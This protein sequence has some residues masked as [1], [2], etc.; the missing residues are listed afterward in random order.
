M[1]V[2]QLKI[3]KQQLDDTE[4]VTSA[5][6]PRPAEGKRVLIHSRMLTLALT[7]IND[8]L[9]LMVHSATATPV[10]SHVNDSEPTVLLRVTTP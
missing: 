9:M 8:S 3:D 2:P 1:T 10:N 6:V 5:E 4:A 7:M